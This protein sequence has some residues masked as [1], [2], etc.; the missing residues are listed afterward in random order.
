MA[1]AFGS[2]GVAPALA[3]RDW[4]WL[5]PL[6]VYALAACLPFSMALISLCKLLLL[7]WALAIIAQSS[8]RRELAGR[9]VGRMSIAPVWGI[10]A[11]LGV[12][13][14]S[15]TYTSVPSAEALKAFGKYGKLLIIPVAL[16]LLRTRREA[17][18]AL[19]CFG[20]TQSFVMLSAWLLWAGASLPWVREVRNA[21]G[22]V[23]TSYLPQSIMTAVLAAIAWHLRGEL[24][25]KRGRLLMICVA[26]LSVLGAL[27][28]L[29]GRTGQVCAIMVV[30]LALFWALPGR[31]RY[32][33]WLAPVPLVLLAFLLSPAFN[34]RFSKVSAEVDAYSEKSNVRTSS[35]ERLNFWRR[36]LQ[37]IAEKPLLGHGVGAWSQQYLRLEG[38]GVSTQTKDVRNPHQEFLLW[39]VHA[40]LLGFAVFVGWLASLAW[41]AWQFEPVARHASLSLLVVLVL[42]CALNSALFDAFIGDFFCAM[43]GIHLA[44]GLSAPRPA[45][46]PLAAAKA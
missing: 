6:P 13:A 25:S 2:S 11:M 34:E 15:L 42:A 26:V 28:T 41:Q 38:A 16:L 37:A 8:I 20:V 14:L 10:V 1:G 5:R 22:T 39:A 27:V 43:L 33:T 9:V 46:R 30:S 36:S 45:L 12:L 17:L 3:S 7:V 44:L 21:P 18:I 23:F 31:W 24:N 32:V 4:A 40:G 19:V 35:G 29:P